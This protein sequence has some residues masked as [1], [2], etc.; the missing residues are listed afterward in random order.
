ME[1]RDL[2]YQFNGSFETYEELMIKYRELLLGIASL[3]FLAGSCYT[4]LTD[5][6]QEMNGLLTFNRRPKVNPERNAEIHRKPS[7]LNRHR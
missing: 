6:E 7:K 4:Q 3:K 1:K 5:I 2:L